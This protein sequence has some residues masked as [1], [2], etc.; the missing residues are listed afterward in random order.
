MEE[1][2]FKELQ[3][4]R[5]FESKFSISKSENPNYGS[6]LGARDFANSDDFHKYVTTKENYEEYG[7]DYFKEYST[8]NRYFP[9]NKNQ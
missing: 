5:P 1:R 3:E 6:W 2:L 7:T 9:I 4:M 8:S